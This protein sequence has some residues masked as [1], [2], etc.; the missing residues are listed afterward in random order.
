MKITIV[1]PAVI[2]LCIATAVSAQEKG[3]PSKEATRTYSD[4]ITDLVKADNIEGAFKIIREQWL[5]PEEEIANLQTQTV[6]QLPML[7][8]RFGKILEK[9]FMKE[10]VIEDL[11]VRYIYIIKYEKH[12]I[13]W[14]FTF[15][16]PG[17]RWLLNSLKWDAS[18]DELFP[19]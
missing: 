16:K 17:T 10:E 15:Y 19:K 6:S 2:A 5:F 3:F 12:A 14:S 13:R 7:K 18:V 4:K 8:S 1:A 9:K 11:M